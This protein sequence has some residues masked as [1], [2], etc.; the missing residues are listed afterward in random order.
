MDLKVIQFSLI[1]IA[2]ILLGFSI[3]IL[4][5]NCNQ[6]TDVLV[7]EEKKGKPNDLIKE[8]SPYLLQHAYNPVNWKAWNDES[9]ALAKVQNKLIVISVGYS[10]CHWCHVMEEESF[11]NDS[12]A[13][14]MNDKFINIKVDREE[15]PD[16]DQ[17]Y[18]NAVTLMTGSAGW[19]L[20]VIAL[21]DGKPVFGG[22]YFTKDQ[23]LKVLEQTSSLYE[24][25]PQ[26]MIA[27]AEQLTEGVK[28]MDLIEVNND[29]NP[30]KES[31]LE[32][33]V[34][35]LKTNLDFELG[36]QKKA[37]KFPMPSHLNFSLRYAHH[38]NDQQLL[39]YVTTSLDKMANGGLYDQIGGGFSRY[40]VDDKWHVPHFEKMLYD[41]AQL[42]STYA[43]AYK[44]TG[45]KYY[46]QIITETLNFI[47]NKMTST[48]GTF[49]SSIDAD[50]KNESDEL[51]EGVYYTWTKE[52][53]KN[54]LKEDYDLFKQYYNINNIGFWEKGHY[55][56]YRIESDSQFIE[57]NQLDP[58]QFS[59]KLS[60]WKKLLLVER[61]KRKSP[62][63]DGKA[64]TS[65]NAMM[66]NAYLDA[67]KAIGENEYLQI[68]LKNAEFIRDKQ[69]QNNGQ[70]L[71]SYKDEIS[72]IDGF[73]EDYAHVISA[74]INLY[75]VTMDRSWLNLAKDVMDNSIKHFQNKENNMFYFTS[76]N[77][78]NL[79]ARKTEVYDNVI[80]SSNSVQAKNLFQLGL[81]FYDKEYSKLA[82]Q[83]L[84]NVSNDI[85]KSP[86]AFTNWLNLYLNY[87]KPFY[88]VAISGPEAKIKLK[89]IN[90]A[91]L[92]NIIVA[93][94]TNDDDLPLLINKFA[95][96]NTSIFVCVNGTCKL[97]V[98]EVKM[99]I[100][101]INK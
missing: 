11:E 74:F 99:A 33:M 57:K 54:I 52:E 3:F 14:L 56:L 12:V 13:K 78:S 58:I 48:E 34:A 23:W 100:N 4:V 6:K 31:Q 59:S 85:E 53:L 50:S 47:K 28:K 55:I 60:E 73:L 24:T 70:L 86:T 45:N 96:G 64:L 41:N 66:L 15:R 76:N 81:Y 49:Y 19:P 51:E 5:I 9:L 83:M 93:G 101:Q 95:E 82:R 29:E 72:S 98:Q 84:S 77:G 44:L 90:T 20:N 42:V 35:N 65:W 89:D 79:I 69:L 91:Y 39:E 62:R 25:E 75:Q 38:Y 46:K 10:A 18:V 21:P 36:G 40:S 67:Y 97:P 17:V 61:D 87:V 27:Y 1:R 68:A 7:Q 30:F 43:N 26:K 94:S 92:P 80:P 2:Q 37:P 63:L 8:T 32:N 71:H 88:E 22:T 16:V